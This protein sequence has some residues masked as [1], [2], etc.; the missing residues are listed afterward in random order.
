M[1]SVLSAWPSVVVD[2]A[3]EKLIRNGALVALPLESAKGDH[4]RAYTA[5]GHFLC[6]LRSDPEKGQWHPEKVFPDSRQ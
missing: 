6:V 4:C 5:S 2:E 3:T 1:D